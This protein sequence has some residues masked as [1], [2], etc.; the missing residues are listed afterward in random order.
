MLRSFEREHPLTFRALHHQRVDL[1]MQNRL[2]DLVRLAVI[3]NGIFSTRFDAE[4]EIEDLAIRGNITVNFLD[5]TGLQADL[6]DTPAVATFASD[7]V[8]SELSYASG[9]IAF[10]NSNDLSVGFKRTGATP[11]YSYVLAFSPDAA[12]LDG[13]VHKLKVKLTTRKAAGVQA[14]NGY[15]AAKPK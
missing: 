8:L 10:R 6:P 12:N 4:S 13:K 5:P 1:S 9:G 14:R 7:A 3:S 2:D 11:E 15:F